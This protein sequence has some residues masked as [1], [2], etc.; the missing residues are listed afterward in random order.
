MQSLVRVRVYFF[1]ES[2]KNRYKITQFQDP[3]ILS[4]MYLNI[5]LDLRKKASGPIL[6]ARMIMMMIGEPGYSI[7]EWYYFFF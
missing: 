2:Y 5:L 7:Y 1:E 4:G 6:S 3:F